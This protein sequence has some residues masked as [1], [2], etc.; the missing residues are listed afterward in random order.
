MILFIL[1]KN[2]RDEIDDEKK[3]E[4]EYV[5]DE[6][7]NVFEDASFARQRERALSVEVEISR[8][9]G[10][11]RE[12]RGVVE[13]GIG[14]LRRRVGGHGAFFG[15]EHEHVGRVDEY[16]R[17][18]KRGA[19]FVRA[20]A[21]KLG[22]ESRELD[23]AIDG[24]HDV[25]DA[26]VEVHRVHDG[27]F[28]IAAKVG[29][30]LGVGHVDEAARVADERE[31]EHGVHER[32]VEARDAQIRVERFLSKVAGREDAVGD[33]IGEQSGEADGREG[34]KKYGVVERR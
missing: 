14:G 29:G 18:Q 21:T 17:D 6:V 1:E 25:D 4:R 34:E 8:R 32:A 5:S 30:Q 28:E 7:L 19:Y 10:R 23:E 3:R 12:R 9:C 26:A 15:L 11:R 2:Q 16:T 20:E 27:Y 22:L 31:R 13:S 33:E 24:E